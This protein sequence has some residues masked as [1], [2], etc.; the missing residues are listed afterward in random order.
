MGN[1]FNADWHP[2]CEVRTR[3]TR[4]KH[5]VRNLF[6]EQATA[7]A[8][9]YADPGPRTLG[10]RHLLSRQRFALEMVES[11]IPSSSRILDAGCGS[12][13]MAAKLIERGYAVWGI[14]L[15]APMIR[16]ARKLCGAA[17]FGV[18]DIEQIPFPD[19]TFDVVVSLGVIEYLESDEQA[20]REIRRVLRPGG[21]A[22]IAIANGRSVVRRIDGVLFRL[23]SLLR[24]AYHRLKYRFRGNPVPPPAAP[25][26][27]VPRALYQRFYR[28]RWLRLLRGVNLEPEEWIC[29]SWGWL[30]SP[31][32]PLVQLLS[33]RQTVFR[34]G[35]E[36]LLG[37]ALLSRA[38][39]K[40]VR[41]RA[42]NWFAAEHIIRVRA[43]KEN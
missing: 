42:F 26:A 4:S 38:S 25:A 43:I 13:E 31:L 12:G 15:A 29:H 9:H 17:C 3:M 10:A 22:V 35:I 27:T 32:G 23:V 2:P 18:A 14:D 6:S 36:R 20:L 40:I 11:A 7:W 33:M 21:R 34:R 30:R 1:R 37:R 28:S 39:E 24:P 5:H 16:H 19:N 41:S 8:A